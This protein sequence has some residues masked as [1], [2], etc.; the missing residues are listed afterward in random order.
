MYE[1]K[2]YLFYITEILWVLLHRKKLLKKNP[3]KQKNPESFWVF[4]WSIPNSYPPLQSINV[5]SYIN[6]LSVK[7]S[8][9]SWNKYNSAAL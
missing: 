9:I 4:L 1:K 3:K 6:R 2:K 7:P 5:L 8:Y